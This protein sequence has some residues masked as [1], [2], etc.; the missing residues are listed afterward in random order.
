MVDAV[1]GRRV[2]VRV[3]A[4][5][6]VG[7]WYGG[8]DAGELSARRVPVGDGGGR[9]AGGGIV[10]EGVGG[11]ALVGHRMSGGWG[12]RKGVDSVVRALF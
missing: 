2:R 7:R 3:H 10:F 12:W 9:F 8:G 5:H 4:V 6:V 1:A 11:G